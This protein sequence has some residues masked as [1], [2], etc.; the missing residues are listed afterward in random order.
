MHFTKVQGTGNDFILIEAGRMRRDWAQMAKTM[1]ERRFGIGADGLLLLLSSK[2]ADFRMRIFNVDGSE[3]EMCGNAIRCLVRYIFEA[4]LIS[5][6][7]T[8]LSIETLSGIKRVEL[9]KT[10][11]KLN[12]LRVGMGAPEFR[13]DRIPVVIPQSLGSTPDVKLLCYPVSI[14]GKTL[15]LNFISMGNPH[16]VHFTEGPVSDFPLLELGPYIENNQIFPRR[17]NFEIAR[18]IGPRLIEERTWERGVGETLACGTGA[19]AVAVVA[20]LLGYTG[21]EVDIKVRGGMLTIEWDGSGEVYLNGP[22]EISFTGE[23]PE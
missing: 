7:V 14:N 6:K 9:K 13:A 15:P 2:T 21:P 3:A 10:R 1:C 23:W 8:E 19:C 17:T 20:Q 12:S 11:G 4:G 16:A 5:E 22:A 18:V